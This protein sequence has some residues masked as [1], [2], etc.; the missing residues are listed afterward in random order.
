MFCER[1]KWWKGSGPLI[2]EVC[3]DSFESMKTAQQAG[4][5][6]IELCSALSLGGLT[7]SY[8]L[9]KQAKTLSGLEVFVMIRPR[10]GDFLY[11]DDEFQ[12]MK[13]DVLIA[14]QMGF[15][16]IVTGVLLSDGR[17][18]LKRMKE[19]VELAHPLQVVLHRAFDRALEPHLMMNELIEIGICRI[20]TSGQQPTALEGMD[21]IAQLQKQFGDAITIM[22]GSGIN[23]ENI[24][25]LIEKTGCTHYHLSGKVFVESDMTYRK[26]M[27]NLQDFF[28]Q[29]ADY[30][31]ILAV[32]NQLDQYKR[33]NI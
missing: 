26:E 28:I 16:G 8:G 23:H 11:T 18:D 29:K 27:D 24:Q 4:A 22:P 17:I 21:Y 7:P 2:L 19:L 10:G 31:R 3:V 12:T 32:R 13:E 5:N 30:N 33:K 15:E 20:L 1:G 9:M 6:R 14:K 25:T